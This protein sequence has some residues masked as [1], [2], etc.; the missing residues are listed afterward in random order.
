ML[1]PLKYEPGSVCPDGEISS[2]LFRGRGEVTVFEDVLQ[3]P[4]S[5]WIKVEQYLWILSAVI[6]DYG[7][8]GTVITVDDVVAYCGILV[9]LLFLVPRPKISFTGMLSQ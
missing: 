3:V 9:T 7:D 6:V 5:I 8:Y 4:T 1:I 2:P